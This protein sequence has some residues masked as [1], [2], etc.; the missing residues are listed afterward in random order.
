MAD[1]RTIN[2]QQHS[3]LGMAWCAGW[4]FTVGYPGLSFWSG[5]LALVVWPSVLGAHLMPAAGWRVDDADAP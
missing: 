5:V 3:G 1:K 2:I 4:L